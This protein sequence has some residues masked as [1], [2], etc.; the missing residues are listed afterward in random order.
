MVTY[1]DLRKSEKQLKVELTK[2]K[3]EVDF[4]QQQNALLLEKYNQLVERS[5][6]ELQ[7]QFLSNQL[8][9]CEFEQYKSSSQQTTT[10][11][12]NKVAT[13]EESLCKKTERCMLLEDKL[14]QM[15]IDPLSLS[16]FQI[17]EEEKERLKREESEF[18]EYLQSVLS[19]ISSQVLS[20]QEM[21][22]KNQLLHQSLNQIDLS[23]LEIPTQYLSANF[24]KKSLCHE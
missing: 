10:L 2:A 15:G 8:L 9:K 23:S 11:L 3:S 12:N 24:W 13:L 6:Q 14:E 17:N 4:L 21:I 20:T 22:E 18:A 16:T 5:K 1:S 7:E 19:T